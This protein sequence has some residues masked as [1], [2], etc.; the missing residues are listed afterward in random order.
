L[1]NTNRYPGLAR[2]PI[3]HNASSVINAISNGVITMG[4]AV[5]L[6]TT[7]P[8]SEILPRVE[9]LTGTTGAGGAK[10]EAQ[11]TYGIAVGG[12]TDGIYGNGT[13]ATTD[14][15]R[16]TA[17]AGQAAVIVTQGRCLAR[18]AGVKNLTGAETVPTGEAIAIGDPLV[19]SEQGASAQ[20]GGG[21]SFTGSVLVALN[22]TTSTAKQFVI[23]R[24]LQAVAADDTDII[25]VDIQR[26]GDGTAT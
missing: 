15:N 9:E 14:T 1:A 19:A 3:D 17:S 4:S 8:G 13:T 7:I 22:G 21:P 24:A 5:K 18:V 2:G 26:E 20:G 23:A 12:D 25:A 16:A 10:T 6:N 11:P